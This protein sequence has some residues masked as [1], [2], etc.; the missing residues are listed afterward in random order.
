MAKLQPTQI[1]KKVVN[2][3]YMNVIVTLIV[4]FISKSPLAVN[5]W[6]QWIQDPGVCLALLT[7]FAAIVGYQT[8][9]TEF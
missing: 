7:V 1:S 6:L 8:E 5:A 3:F 2:T 4:G 9:E